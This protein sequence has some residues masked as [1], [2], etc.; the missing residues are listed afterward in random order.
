MT[1]LLRTKPVT[2]ATTKRIPQLL[3]QCRQTKRTKSSNG[4]SNNDK[5]TMSAAERNEALRDANEKMKFYYENRPSLA[6]INKNKKKFGD[7]NHHFR[8]AGAMSTFFCLFLFTPFLGRVSSIGIG[9]D[10]G[11]LNREKISSVAYAISYIIII[12]LVCLILYLISFD[13]HY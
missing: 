1:F 7:E 10:V 4:S 11:D 12:S 13:N 6:V 2:T 5:K 3:Q 8:M 9:L